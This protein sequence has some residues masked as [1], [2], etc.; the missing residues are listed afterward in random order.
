MYYSDRREQLNKKVICTAQLHFA[1]IR[2]LEW[3]CA[4][5]KVD[6]M[7]NE[8]VSPCLMIDCDNLQPNPII[9]ICA[10]Q[11][12]PKNLAVHCPGMEICCGYATSDVFI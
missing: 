1:I 10:N 7:K 5:C 11:I 4:E 9:I 6:T 12:T 3:L 2:F 8:P